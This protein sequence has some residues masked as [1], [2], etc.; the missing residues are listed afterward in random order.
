MSITFTA[1]TADFRSINTGSRVEPCLCTQMGDAFL[2]AMDLDATTAVY[3]AELIADLR[4]EAFEGCTTCKG[5]GVV[6]YETDLDLNFANTTARMVAR[7]AGLDLGP[8]QLPAEALRDLLAPART[9]NARVGLGAVMPRQLS[10][11]EQDGRITWGHPTPDSTAWR[12]ERL[13]AF[14]EDAISRGAST[15]TWG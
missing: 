8:G 12:L 3:S 2:V 1:R 7:T 11:F 9:Q 13:G 15:I 10:L 6:T 5:S 14:V 4:S